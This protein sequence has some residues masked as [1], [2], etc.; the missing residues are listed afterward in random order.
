MDASAP[1]PSSRADV[2][3]TRPYRR[4]FSL[5]DK[6]SHPSG[7]LN[8]LTRRACVAMLGSL[9]HPWVLCVSAVT[10]RR[11]IALPLGRAP[12]GYGWRLDPPSRRHPARRARAR[13]LAHGRRRHRAGRPRAAGPGRR[14]GREAE[15]AG[16]R[17]RRAGRRGGRGV[18]LP[19][20]DQ[21]EE[22]ARRARGGGRGPPLPRRGRLDR[23]LHRLPAAARRADGARARR[24]LRAARLAAAPGLPRA[25]DG[26]A[27]R[28][29]A[30]RLLPAATSPS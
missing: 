22:R 18:R 4:G 28:Q 29:G 13:V 7:S 3:L 16:A 5:P 12:P 24:R 23:R 26:A 30:R 19:R 9:L 10:R 21:A 27:Q 25:G 6:R 11:G 17:G 8:R 1:S 15:R 2:Q 20:R 14:R